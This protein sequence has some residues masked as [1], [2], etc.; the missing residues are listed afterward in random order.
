MLTAKI[1]YTFTVVRRYRSDFPTESV[2]LIS[3]ID[4]YALPVEISV[5]VIGEDNDAFSATGD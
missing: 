5:V 1:N 4:I 2:N 3:E